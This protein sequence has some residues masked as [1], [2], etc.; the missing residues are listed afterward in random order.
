MLDLNDALRHV[1]SMLRRLVRDNVV[2]VL[3][4][5]P[6]IERVRV[7]PGQ[8]DQVVVNL[9]VNAGDAMPEG[10]TVTLST[11]HTTLTDADRVEHP[12]VAPGEFVTLAVGDTGV[13]M[14]EATRARAFEP[15]F[16]TKPVG[17]GTGLG[18]STVYG[19][20]KQSGGYVW[21]TSQPGAGTT[22]TVCLPVAANA[23]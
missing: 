15:F 20:V 12:F 11:R 16:S 8:L 3:D 2:L 4:L 22:V 19:I 6:S 9:V 5:D 18:L 13:G 7:D 21:L 10:G 1:H 14:D 17:K 23:V